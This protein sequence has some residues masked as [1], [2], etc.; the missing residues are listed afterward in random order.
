MALELGDF[1]ALKL[2]L[3]RMGD[4][5]EVANAEL[6]EMA[7]EVQQKAKNMAPWEYHDL[8]EAIQLRETAGQG[9]GGRFVKGV[10]NYEVYINLDHPVTDS[11]HKGVSS[12]RD[13]AWLVHEHM[14]WGSTPGSIVM[15]NGDPLMP[16]KERNVGPNGEERGGKFLERA[17][18]E[19][20]DQVNQR[21]AR[22]IHRYFML[23]N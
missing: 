11:K 17:A 5:G 14:G 12:V 23:D 20:A 22:V 9:A 7:V 15:K 3:R 6:R 1:E 18:I 4:V 13:Y 8:Q 10:R 19:L 16:N 21:L 2:Q